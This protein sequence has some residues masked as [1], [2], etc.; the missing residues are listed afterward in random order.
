MP[1]TPRKEKSGKRRRPGRGLDLTAQQWVVALLVGVATVTAA[2]FGW[3]AAATGSTAA[4]DDRQSISETIAVEQQRLDIGLAVSDDARNYTRY[5]AGYAV[6]AE[7]ENQAE[8]LDRA[9]KEAAATKARLDA[10]R[11]RSSVTERAADAGVFGA[12]TIA[13]D[14]NYPKPTPRPFSLEKQLRAR[15][16]EEQTGIDSP[17]RLDPDRWAK[18]AEQI[19]DRINGLALWALIV[20]IAVLMF[21]IA[22]ANSARRTVFYGAMAFGV[23]ILVAG[24]TLG[25]SVDFFA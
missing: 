19:R 4:Y 11:L 5:L 20:L 2:G 13:D 10:R 8:G 24:A 6:A 18:E 23:V 21:S 25:L 12:S 16:A 15:T 14:L 1:G 7:L 17:G 3:R 22:E 9:G